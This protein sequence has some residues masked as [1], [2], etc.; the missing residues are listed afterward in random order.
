[1]VAHSEKKLDAS[2]LVCV[3]QALEE[4]YCEVAEGGRFTLTEEPFDAGFQVQ[5]ALS[6]HDGEDEL[7]LEV[8]VR[9]EDHPKLSEEDR[10]HLGLDI[11]GYLFDQHLVDDPGV[12]PSLDWQD[13]DYAGVRALVRGDIRRPA[14][15]AAA[16]DLL[17]DFGGS[18]CD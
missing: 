15:E 6:G 4:R 2:T 12:L 10:V 9:D 13:F 3:I 16:N 11:I 1:M 7:I 17:K 5:C 18:D 14:L 8:R